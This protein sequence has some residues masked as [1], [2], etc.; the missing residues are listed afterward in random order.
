VI[1]ILIISN[2]PTP[3]ND[4]LFSEIASRPHVDLHVTYCADRHANR[5]WTLATNKG[6]EYSILRGVTLGHGIHFN[7]GVVSRIRNLQPDIVV[8]TGSYLIPT[9]QMAMAT[10]WRRGIPWLYWGEELRNHRIAPPQAAF[11][12]L[13]RRPL[14]WATGVLAIGRKAVASYQRAG[15]SPER[16]VNFH[17]YA[18]TVRFSAAGQDRAG[19]RQR[20]CRRF[21]IDPS[22]TVFLFAGQLIHR[23]GV[24]TLMEA[25]GMLLG[26]GMKSELIVAGGGPLE[27]DVRAAATALDGGKSVRVVGF[28]QPDQLPELF[29]GSDCFILPS[30]SE[31]WGLVVSEAMA[32]GTPVIS[33]DQVNAGV[34][35]IQNGESG[36]LFRSGDAADLARAMRLVAGNPDRLRLSA[37]VLAAVE[38]ESL[39]SATTRLLAIVST[40]LR[41]DQISQVEAAGS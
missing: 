4:A 3:N 8:L 33:S 30:R 40:V 21:E 37:N 29:A 20:L 10:L 28:V 12:S 39:E 31:G 2:I 35:L 19:A 34:E 11:R 6:Y 14:R 23:K 25:H 5:L 9:A 24:D 41:G 22:S 17:Y 38:E 7:P 26:D 18:D 32:A 13:L 1:R 16:I 36:F 15:V 27:A